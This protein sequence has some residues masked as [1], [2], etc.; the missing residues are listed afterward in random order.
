MD[1]EK[2]FQPNGLLAQAWPGY[3]LR[4]GQLALAQAV[5]TTLE[6][7]RACLAEAGTGVG[8]S[9]AY[10]IPGAAWALEHETRLLIATHT[11]ALQTQ[12]TDQELPRL[13]SGE[14][15]GRPF[16]SALCLGAE[17]Y[18]CLLRLLE[19]S[20]QEALPGLDAGDAD[21]LR[22]LLAWCREPVSGLQWDA[23]QPM[24]DRVWRSACV[25]TELCPG[26]RCAYFTDCFWQLARR[27]Q[28]EAD[29]LVTN[30]HLLLAH[31]TSAGQVLPEFGAL[32]VDEA[33]E[34][35]DVATTFLSD[36]V[37]LA[38]IRHLLAEVT[39]RG[40]RNYLQVLAR[41]PAR[42]AADLA[43][44]ARAVG[45]GQE[46]WWRALE[47]LVPPDQDT[48]RLDRRIVL[49]ELPAPEPATELA[50]LLK[51][52][53]PLAEGEAEAQG[54]AA[55]QGRLER[56]LAVQRQWHQ[57]TP[58]GQVAWLER[59]RRPQ[60][61][62]VQLL[63]TPLDLGGRL[64][65]LLSENAAG[66]ILT[67]ATLSVGGSFAYVR[68]RLGL[69]QAGEVVAASPFDYAEQAAVY[70]P[71]LP[72]PLEGDAFAREMWRA[73][74]ELIT[75]FD[76][77]VFV[78][79]TSRALLRR[80]GEALRAWQPEREWLVQG[81]A[82]PAELLARFRRSGRAVLLGV[83]TWWQG[84]DVPGE[85]LRCVVITRLPFDV[86]THPLHQARAE[87]LEQAGENPFM[88][89]SLPRAVLMLRQ[90][91]GRLIRS[92][93]DRGLVAI[94]D[95]RVRTRPW[96]RAFLE[97]LPECPRLLEWRDVERF[98]EQRLGLEIRVPAED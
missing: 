19:T 33:H 87:Q 53:A 65:A 46:A 24:P 13:E 7:G 67:S 54:L 31:L 81:E 96:G 37:S 42:E 6:Q 11:K 27:L 90:G 14:V 55:W 74:R 97:A 2:I 41:V 68:S 66:V 80:T 93:T 58:A 64:G 61:A 89:Y 23:P 12:L 84:V 88:A 48:W 16:R 72:E 36:T 70:L 82:S 10:L 86:P 26:R 76:G 91:F 1:L 79:L 30:H 62:N 52:T 69:E 78:L 83:D 49:P 94:L 18:V 73:L 25:L 34:L 57:E 71:D 85:A 21:S 29:V 40:R 9:L 44:R 75:L 59:S 60:G 5:Q 98:A 45:S 95:A 17:N 20:R 32:V 22:S 63:L 43:R 92:R 47:A 8:K 39:G 28:R 15:I 38:E 3:Q 51:E 35:E 77:G 4:E 56:A 50:A